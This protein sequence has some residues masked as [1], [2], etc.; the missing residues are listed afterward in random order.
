MKSSIFSVI[1]FL[2]CFGTYAQNSEAIDCSEFKKGK[3]FFTPPNGGEVTFKRTRKKQ[4][5]RYN[6]ENQRFKFSIKWTSPCEY[7][8]TLIK[9]KGLDRELKKQIIG[10]TL[11]CK[12]LDADLGHYKVQILSENNNEIVTIYSR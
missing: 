12:V 10:S 11:E 6:D 1:I 9:A 7:Q 3:F 4:T 5:E 2:F 8:L